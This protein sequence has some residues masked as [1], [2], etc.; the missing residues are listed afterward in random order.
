MSTDQRWKWAGIVSVVSVGGV[1][2]TDIVANVVGGYISDRIKTSWDVP[3]NAP[4]AQAGSC[5]RDRDRLEHP[6]SGKRGTGDDGGGCAE[7]GLRSH[8]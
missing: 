2:I 7:T 4:A 1:L 5:Q 3:Q 8:A 6:A